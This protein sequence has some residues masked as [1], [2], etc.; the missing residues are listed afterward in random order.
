M[1]ALIGRCELSL[2]PHVVRAALPL[3]EVPLF[4]VVS[5]LQVCDEICS[6][7]SYMWN[8]CW[9]EFFVVQIALLFA[10]SGSL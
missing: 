7:N 6:I 1:V 9:R 2:D 3:L 10:L 8:S 5:N 4:S